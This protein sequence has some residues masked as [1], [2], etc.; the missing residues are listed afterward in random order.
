[1]QSGAHMA[2]SIVL[3]GFRTVLN[4]GLGRIQIQLD[5]PRTRQSQQAALS[6]STI[7]GMFGQQTHLVEIGAEHVPT[8]FA[9]LEYLQNAP[10][11]GKGFRDAQCVAL[12]HPGS[13]A[14][15]GR[16]VAFWTVGPISPQNIIKSV[17][18]LWKQVPQLH[19]GSSIHQSDHLRD[20]LWRGT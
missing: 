2:K 8:L 16:R 14:G 13:L 19:D 3:V 7:A 9:L 1:M 4:S 15:R 12:T 17:R 10:G 5:N 6:A 18:V 11:G 20:Q